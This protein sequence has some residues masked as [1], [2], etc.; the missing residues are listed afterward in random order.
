M[1][2]L[3]TEIQLPISLSR[4]NRAHK[5]QHFHPALKYLSIVRDNIA[6]LNKLHLHQC[7][8]GTTL[9]VPMKKIKDKL[10]DGRQW[11]RPGLQL[12]ATLSIVDFKALAVT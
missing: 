8:A 12:N 9:L 4:N 6:S 2:N 3:I 11:T 10:K 5:N 7:E 1:R